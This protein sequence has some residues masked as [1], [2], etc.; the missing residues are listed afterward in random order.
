MSITGNP[1]DR[2]STDHT[3]P[4]VHKPGTP[5]SVAIAITTVSSI[6]QQGLG[7]RIGGIFQSISM[8]VAGLAIALF[9]N[10][11]LTGIIACVVPASFIMYGFTIPAD[12]KI[13]KRIIMAQTKAADLAEEA[14]A[15]IRTVKSFNAE[16]IQAN[17]YGALL[18]RAKEEG[19]R[20]APLVGIQHF[21]GVFI[22]LCAF[23]LCFWY[24]SKMFENGDIKDV[25]T[26]ITRVS[27][28]L[29]K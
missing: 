13:E 3:N 22:Y 27:A 1:K 29:L 12:V 15:T 2:L 6:V 20:K 18:N 25:G 21:I 4:A 23:A 26:I 5:G 9:A 16:R 11:T 17:K 7:E 10:K 24:G 14:L 19:L 28:P 8:L